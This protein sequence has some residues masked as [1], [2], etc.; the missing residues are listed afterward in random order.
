MNPLSFQPFGGLPD[1][2]S[3][4]RGRVAP[5]EAPGIGFETKAELRK[6]FAGLESAR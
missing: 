4:E 1:G 6:L 2:V 5:P 3:P